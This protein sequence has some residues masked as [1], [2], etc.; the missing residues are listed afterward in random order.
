[1]SLI[2]IGFCGLNHVH[3][4][5]LL[6]FHIAQTFPRKVPPNLRACGDR[7]LTN[8]IGYQRFQGAY[9]LKGSRAQGLSPNPRGSA[10]LFA[11]SIFPTDLLV[12]SLAFVAGAP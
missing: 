6:F 4:G 8:E 5:T 9:L 2:S 3:Q 10:L 11:S 12:S 1:M 7:M